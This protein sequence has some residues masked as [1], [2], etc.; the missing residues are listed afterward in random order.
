MINYNI[1]DICHFL[2]YK[3][4]IIHQLGVIK[5]EEKLE[6]VARERYQ[7]VSEKEKDK[8]SNMVVKGIEIFLKMK[9]TS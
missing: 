1:N 4:Y 7:N 2:L 5:S 6:K 8:N 3:E 9:N